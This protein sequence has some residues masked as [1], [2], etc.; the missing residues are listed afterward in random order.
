MMHNA[1]KRIHLRV[2]GRVQ[3]VG[4][5]WFVV[6]AAERLHLRG[7]VRNAPDGSVEVE[8]EGSAV[9]LDALRRRLET[10]PPA[11][12]V[13]RVDDLPPGENTLP[14]EFSIVR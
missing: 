13:T 2:V 9:A 7:W 11:A 3:G 8:A 4:F 5:R 10:G 12:R 14:A 1:A 6:S